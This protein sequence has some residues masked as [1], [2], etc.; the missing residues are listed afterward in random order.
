MGIEVLQAFLK[1]YRTIG[2]DTN[3]FIYVVE[4]HPVYLRFVEP[5][6]QWLDKPQHLAITSTL[7]M[8]ELLVK[9]YRDANIDLI[10]RFYSV[11]STHPRLH[12]VELTLPI[13]DEASRLR[14]EYNLRTPDAIHA[15]TALTS[16]VQGFIANDP[17]FEKVDGL[18]VLTLSRLLS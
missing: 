6:F 12:W 4:E 18:D 14:A 2:I 1:R 10:N 13:A 5:V 3:V 17:A 16:H 9:P 11:L 8:L 7:T 15:A